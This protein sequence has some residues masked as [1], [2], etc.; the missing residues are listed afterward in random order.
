MI[1]Y[2]IVTFVIGFVIGG[3]VGVQLN[4]A[5]QEAIK[6]LEEQEATAAKEDLSKIKLN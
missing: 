4:K 2:I 3:L 5:D 1:V 6:A